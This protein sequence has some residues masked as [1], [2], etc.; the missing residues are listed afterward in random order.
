MD[1]NRMS[2]QISLQKTNAKSYYKDRVVVRRFTYDKE[3]QKTKAGKVIFSCNIHGLPN[4]LP[5]PKIEEFQ[6]TTEEH[7]QFVDWANK[8]KESVKEKKMNEYL[9]DI[10]AS[11]NFKARGLK[12]YTSEFPVEQIEDVE[13][14]IK[15]LKAELTRLKKNAKKRIS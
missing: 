10:S 1:T 4:E 2:L 7:Q 8:H 11:L 15:N 14:A 9:S 6:V 12:R 3:T 13:V 5:P